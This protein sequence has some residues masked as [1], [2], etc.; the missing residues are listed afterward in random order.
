MKK[1]VLLLCLCLSFMGATPELTRTQRIEQTL[2]ICA[3]QMKK[4]VC[5][6]I[7]DEKQYPPDTPGP[8]ILGVGRVPLVPYIR[9]QN[10]QGFMCQYAEMECAKNPTGDVCTVA[11]AIWGH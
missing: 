6:V 1:L 9:L 3:E 7:R 10:Q 4:N 2:R 5:T 8:F 11:V